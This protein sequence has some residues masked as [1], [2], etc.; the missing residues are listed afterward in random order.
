[1]A[2]PKDAESLFEL[3][4]KIKQSW[5]EGWL[6]LRALCPLQGPGLP[7]PPWGVLSRGKAE[8]WVRGQARERQLNPGGGRDSGPWGGE[9]GWVAR[10]EGRHRWWR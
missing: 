8:S 4:Q 1:M 10:P 6:Q 9:S 7:Q 3:M 2:P 5:S